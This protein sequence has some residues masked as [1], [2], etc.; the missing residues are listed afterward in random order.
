MKFFNFEKKENPTGS[1][2]FM[3]HNHT[4]KTKGINEYIQ[5]GYNTNAIVYRCI[6]EI[7]Q[8]IASCEIEVKSNGTVLD[9]HEILK[10]LEKPNPVESGQQFLKRVFVD[11][12]ITGNMFITKFPDEGKAIELWAQSPR[13]MSV[14]MG[15]KGIPERYEFSAGKGIRSFKVNQM[16]GISQVFHFKNYDPYNPSIGLSPLSAAG[17]PADILNA[18]LKWNYSLLKNS[19]RPS[20][21]INFVGSPAGE[22]IQRLKDYF[23]KAFQGENNAGEIP[24]LTDGAQWQ[25][26][27]HSPKEMDFLSTMKEMTKYVASVYGVPL[28]LVDNDAASFN[29]ME[30]A[31]ERLW[32][33]TVIPLFNEF[34]DSFGDWLFMQYGEGGKNLELSINMDSIPALEGLRA[35]RNDRVQKLVSGGL[36]TI[37]EGRVAIDYDEVPDGDDLFIPSSL[38]PLSMS[39]DTQATDAAMVKSFRSMGY[40]ND[41]IYEATGIR[42]G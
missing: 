39:K 25:A 38:L 19:A 34:L 33:D 3:G 32:T 26:T 42:A 5:E 18:G 7:S 11:Y 17:I 13:Y 37:N 2:M 27:D 20:G 6:K 1:A 40:S 36:L 4:L 22:V 29:N 12:L 24:M 10:L 30:Q 9:D 21:I 35:K 23:K 15:E 31:K 16:T 28:P 8:A 41:E 14:V